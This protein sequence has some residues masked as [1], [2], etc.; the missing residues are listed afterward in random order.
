MGTKSK[1]PDSNSHRYGNYDEFV[2]KEGKYIPSIYP[3]HVKVI[4]DDSALIEVNL[5]KGL[6]FENR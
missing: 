6:S 1:P 4:D 5:E 2:Q 3:A